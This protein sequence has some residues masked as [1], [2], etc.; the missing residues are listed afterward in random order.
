MNGAEGKLVIMPR[1]KSDRIDVDLPENSLFLQEQTDTSADTPT[2]ILVNGKS[3][4]HQKVHKIPTDVNKED[5]IERFKMGKEVDFITVPNNDY[6]PA[7]QADYE[8]F[9]ISKQGSRYRFR[10]IG[11]IGDIQPIRL[12]VEDHTFTVI[13]ADSIDVES[14]SGLDALW[15]ANGERYDIVIDTK[16][17]PQKS[18]YKI[19][20]YSP[21]NKKTEICSLAWLKYPDQTVDNT[22]EADCTSIRNLQLTKVLNPVPTDFSDWGNPDFI[23]PVNLTAVAQADSIDHVSVPVLGVVSTVLN[24]QYLSM[25]NMTFNNYSMAYPSDYPDVPFLFQSPT[26]SPKD[27]PGWCGIDCEP[28]W[29]DFVELETECSRYMPNTETCGIQQPPNQNETF[30]CHCP[31]VIKQPYFKP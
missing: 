2:N 16:S 4:Q 25:K 7:T 17:S 8:V 18:P 24:T 23:Y 19:Y 22:I 6:N 31:H 21:L 13:A 26:P 10:I 15:V 1:T 14:V 27:N 3:K 29:K 30:K 9:N 20:F 11:G 12:S 5:W 28:K